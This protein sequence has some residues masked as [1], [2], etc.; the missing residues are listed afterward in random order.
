MLLSETQLLAG[1][2][3]DPDHAAAEGHSNHKCAPQISAQDVT[4]TMLY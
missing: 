3:T 1:K 2:Q 4:L